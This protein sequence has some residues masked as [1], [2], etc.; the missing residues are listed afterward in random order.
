MPTGEVRGLLCQKCN[1]MLGNAQ[2]DPLILD[3]AVR[4]LEKNAAS[5][6]QTKA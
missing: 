4:Y 2:D 1:S 6:P 3:A 5:C